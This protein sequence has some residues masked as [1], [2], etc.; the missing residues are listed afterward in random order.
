MA[1]GSVISGAEP[2]S[3]NRRY[4]LVRLD[5]EAIDDVNLGMG[6]LAR[7]HKGT[8]ALFE[9][10]KLH[11]GVWLPT[12][13]TYTMSARVLLLR[14]MRTSVISEFSNY[15]KTAIPGSVARTP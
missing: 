9:R 2:G 3:A 12:R 7:V 1:N 14:Q 6:L 10:H 13:A 11:D 4:E 5:V 8:V 15:R